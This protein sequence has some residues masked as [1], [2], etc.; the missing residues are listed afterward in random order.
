MVNP[1]YEVETLLCSAVKWLYAVVFLLYAVV[2]VLYAVLLSFYSTDLFIGCKLYY[3]DE[4][5]WM[6]S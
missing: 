6:H 5:I 4:I 2:S 1:I 3:D